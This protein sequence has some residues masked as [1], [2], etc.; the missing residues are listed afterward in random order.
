MSK[1]EACCKAEATTEIKRREYTLQVC[2][3]CKDEHEQ[4]QI[5]QRIQPLVEALCR[6]LNGGDKKRIVKAFL[7]AFNR[8]HRYLQGSFFQLMWLFFGEYS[9]QNKA[10][11]FDG[12]NEHCQ[13]MAKK[14]YEAI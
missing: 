7:Q 11:F 10:K 8:E 12:R 13:G 2:L 1:C 6:E 4:E 9:S 14:W 5:Y 3:D